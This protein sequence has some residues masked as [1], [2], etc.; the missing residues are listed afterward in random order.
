MEPEEMIGSLHEREP[1]PQGQVQDDEL[2]GLQRLTQ[3][4][5]FVDGL[6]GQGMQWYAPATGKRGRQP[7]FSDAAI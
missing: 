6:A 7:T 2:G 1:A 5:R 4:Q 3:G